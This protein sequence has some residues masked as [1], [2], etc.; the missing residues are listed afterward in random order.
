MSRI[1]ELIVQRIVTVTVS[2]HSFPISWFESLINVRCLFLY[3][4]PLPIY[5]YI[6]YTYIIYIL[7]I[8]L[9]IL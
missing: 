6:Y 9:Y 1:D 4:V 7:Y 2:I 3:P 5:M 8:I